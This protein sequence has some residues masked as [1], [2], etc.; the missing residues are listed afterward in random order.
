MG[1]QNVHRIQITDSLVWHVME[2]GLYSEN[3]GEPFKGLSK[4]NSGMGVKHVIKF[5]FEKVTHTAVWRMD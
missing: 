4:A 3:H 5:A 2:F 1:D